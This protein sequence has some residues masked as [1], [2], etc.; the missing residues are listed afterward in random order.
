METV[1]AFRPLRAATG[2]AHHQ[3]AKV[4]G[5]P[6]ERRLATRVGVLR[7]AE[8]FRVASLGRLASCVGHT[9]PAQDV[10]D[11]PDH[12]EGLTRSREVRPA[13]LTPH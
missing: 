13:V 5:S 12:P 4:Q 10:N 2:A 6:P 8:G 1:G 11:S 3:L 7:S 9:A